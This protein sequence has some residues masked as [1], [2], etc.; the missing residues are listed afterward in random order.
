[1]QNPTRAHLSPGTSVT[2]FLGDYGLW[3]A[4][5]KLP[6]RAPIRPRHVGVYFPVLVLVLASFNS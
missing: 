4:Y 2:I 6:G 3:F 1:M 5:R